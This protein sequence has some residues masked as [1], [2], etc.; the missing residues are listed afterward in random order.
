MANKINLNSDDFLNI[1]S[2]VESSGNKYAYRFERGF[3]DKLIN[4][5][6]LVSNMTNQLN[7]IYGFLTYESQCAILSAS[8]GLYQILGYNLYFYNL[9]DKT[10]FEFCIDEGLQSKAIRKFMK[11]KRIDLPFVISDLMFVDS[12]YDVA[13]KGEE[14]VKLIPNL[15]KFIYIYNGSKIGSHSFF[16]YLDRLIKAMRFYVEKKEG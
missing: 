1:L 4:N 11:I 9:I 2:L 5:T 13:E 7:D 16:K 10:I 6:H 15:S 12:H 14:F 3:F 8:Y